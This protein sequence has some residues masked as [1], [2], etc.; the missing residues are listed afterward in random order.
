M[1]VGR[2][3]QKQMKKFADGSEYREGC[4]SGRRWL[5]GRTDEGADGRR[6]TAIVYDHFDNFIFMSVRGLHLRRTISL[7]KPESV[8]SRVFVIIRFTERVEQRQS[9]HG[10]GH[11]RS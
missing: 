11:F 9:A 8:T 6:V 5:F 1:N 4:R 3:G 2:D 10:T 7:G